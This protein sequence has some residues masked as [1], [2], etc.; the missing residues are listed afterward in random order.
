MVVL[1]A[2]VTHLGDPLLVTAGAAAIAVACGILATH[3]QRDFRFVA[4]VCA[5]ALVANV[6]WHIVPLMA[7]LGTHPGR[8]VA[9]LCT[10]A[11]A[12]VLL[13]SATGH[14]GHSFDLEPTCPRPST[15]GAAGT[16]ALTAI[17]LHRVV[18]AMAVVTL[19]AAGGAMATAA[20]AAALLHSAF[21]G[22]VVASTAT[23]HGMSRGLTFV[24]IVLAGC[25]PLA[26]LALRG[27]FG[28]SE[29]VLPLRELVVMAAVGVFAHVAWHSLRY[30][31]SHLAA[32]HVW[33]LF[34]LGFSVVGVAVA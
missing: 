30:A 11:F 18:E 6:S 27:P 19:G 24:W 3:R 15:T 25:A 12:F 28:H 31:R 33:C 8:S 1:H 29:T 34:I 14:H 10:A 20:M 13:S 9:Y 26:G 16:T 22:S 23:L 5:G 32:S 4:A 2:G 17:A 7:T 21:E